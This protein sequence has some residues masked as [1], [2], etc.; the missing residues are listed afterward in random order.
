MEPISLIFQHSP[1]TFSCWKLCLISSFLC[2]FSV[3]DVCCASSLGCIWLF[4]TPRIVARQVP[5]S[6]GIL[7]A[8]IL[9]WVTIPSSRTSSQPR[10]QTQVS[11]I[12][13]GFFTIWATREARLNLLCNTF[14]QWAQP[15]FSTSLT[16][17]QNVPQHFMA[18]HTAHSLCI[19]CF[20]C[21]EHGWFSF[22][23]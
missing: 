19:Y 9:E 7:Q 8:S 21:L 3:K 15:S 11:G 6:M 5:L 1:V 18:L 23:P 10:D 14:T 16:A 22:P 2:S 4:A 17:S 12:A 20:L 13:G